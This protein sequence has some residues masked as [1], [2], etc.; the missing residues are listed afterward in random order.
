MQKHKVKSSVVQLLGVVL[1]VHV[2]SFALYVV[3]LNAALAEKYGVLS[4][5]QFHLLLAAITLPAVIVIVLFER[6]L[7][8]R[9]SFTVMKWFFGIW[10]IAMVYAFLQ[11]EPKVMDVGS[12]PDL[13]KSN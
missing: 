12:N 9:L 3:T 1:L 7:K 11:P 2:L 5:T 6:R 10:C 8:R 13:I 4:N